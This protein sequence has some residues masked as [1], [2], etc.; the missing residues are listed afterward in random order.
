M[1][2]FRQTPLLDGHQGPDQ[3]FYLRQRVVCA[4]EAQTKERDM[5][6]L[7]LAKGPRKEKRFN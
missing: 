2:G 1:K 5:L 3:C 6:P 7:P 4:A